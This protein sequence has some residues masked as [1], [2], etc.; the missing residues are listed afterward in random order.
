MEQRLI[1][2]TK[3]S[4]LSKHGPMRKIRRKRTRRPLFDPERVA[5][6]FHKDALRLRTL[7]NDE[8]IHLSYRSF[9]GFF[10]GKSSISPHDALLGA[11]LAYAWMP[12]ILEFRGDAGEVAGL[13]RKAAKGA[14]LD[15]GELE[16]LASAINNSM[17]GAS[18]LLHFVNPETYA[19]WDSRVY[20][21]L[22]R[23]KPYAQRLRSPE[24]YLEFLTFVRSLVSDSRFP[25]VH[26]HVK[27]VIGYPVTAIRAAEYVMFAKGAR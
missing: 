27:K 24:A 11:S 18:K 15:A 16:V 23:K 10:E 6:R 8:W 20:R 3:D 9:V 19:I 7:K 17:V 26:R 14:D 13:L 25:Q 1:L 22:T 21:Y 4:A 5:D 2:A 12:T